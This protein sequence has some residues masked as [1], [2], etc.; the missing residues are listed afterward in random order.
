M[1]ENEETNL[2]QTT[3]NELTKEKL[4]P[5]DP[6]LRKI[7]DEAE[8]KTKDA[9]K[10]ARK[11]LR[12]SL[13]KGVGK[14]AL[15][16]LLP[17]LILIFMIIGIISFITS[18]PGIVEDMIM[19]TIMEKVDEV[20][21]ANKGPDIYLEELARDPNRTA[22]KE[23]LKYLDD[24]GLE[25][26]SLGFAA[27]YTRNEET[28]EIEYSNQ[29]DLNDIVEMETTTLWSP[30]DKALTGTG[31]LT[32]S[33]PLTEGAKA[34]AKGLL[35]FNSARNYN[36]AV[37][38]KVKSE[39]LIFK[40]IV[41]NERA[42]LVHLNDEDTKDTWDSVK[43]WFVDTFLL[44][45]DSGPA[46]TG[47]I[48]MFDKEDAVIEKVDRKDKVLTLSTV[49]SDLLNA[50]K[51]EPDDNDDNKGTYKQTAKFNL[52]G[53]SGRY[54]MSL[55][56]LLALHLATMTSDL[57]EEMITNKNLQ[58]A[59][60]LDYTTSEYRADIKV[61]YDGK[62]LPIVLGDNERALAEICPPSDYVGITSYSVYVDGEN[63]EKVKVVLKN[64]DDLKAKIKAN[65]GCVTVRSLAYWIEQV[66][67]MGKNHIHET[68]YADVKNE[69]LNGRDELILPYNERIQIENQALEAEA[70]MIEESLNP[71]I[72]NVFDNLLVAAD[73]GIEDLTL[74][75][76]K[77]IKEGLETYTNKAT[78]SI[79]YIKYVIGHWY[80]DVI[81]KTDDSENNFGNINVYDVS[82]NTIELPVTDISNEK[83]EATVVLS[84]GQSY[85]QT[86]QPY[87]IKGDLVTMD[88]EVVENVEGTDLVEKVKNQTATIENDADSD[89]TSTSDYVLGSGY[90]TTKKLFTEGKYYTYDGTQE[91]AKSIWYAK[92]IEN[93]YP[94]YEVTE[95]NSNPGSITAK[96][97][98]QEKREI[99]ERIDNHDG[100]AYVTVS[101]GRIKQAQ[102]LD[103]EQAQSLM[104]EYFNTIS[105]VQSENE[106][107]D[108]D[109]GYGGKIVT[110]GDG[111]VVMWV[112][113]ATG[114][115]EDSDNYGKTSDFY[116]VRA[117]AD[118]HYRTPAYYT[119][120][121]TQESVN[122][123]NSLLDAMGVVTQRQ[124]VSF[125][126]TTASGDVMSLTA[127]SILEGMHTLDSEYIYR[128]LKEFL[129]E[130]GYYTKS[131]FEY[132][133]TNVLTWFLPDYIPETEEEQKHWRQ[134][135]DG[136]ELYYGAILYPTETNEDGEIT[137]KGFE[138]GIDV[139]APGNCKLLSIEEKDVPSNDG[140]STEKETVIEI[141][142]DGLSQPEIGMLDGYTMIIKGIIMNTDDTIKVQNKDGDEFDVTLADIINNLNTYKKVDKDKLY[143]IKAGET[144]GY[145]GSSRIQVIMR[146][147]RG[148]LLDNV[149]DYMSPDKSTSYAQ[150]NDLGYFYFVPYEGSRPGMVSSASGDREVAVGIAQWTTVVRDSGSV[151]NIPVV[152]KKLYE[153]DPVFCSE[154][155]EFF[156]WSEQQIFDDYFN[157]GDELKNAFQAIENKDK[158][159]FMQLQMQ[160]MIEEK[161][162]LLNSRGFGWLMERNPVTVGTV[163]S[164]YNWGPNMGW[165]DHMSESMSDEQIIISMLKYACTKGSTAGD[166][167]RRWNVQAKLALDILHGDFTDIGGWIEN[168]ANYSEYSIGN[169][170]NFLS[171]K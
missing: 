41:S 135:R 166:L 115:N 50:N 132:I 76:I 66:E 103:T 171:T 4:N 27:F 136:D 138:E 29:Q 49:T 89:V 7:R 146:N 36:A 156:N 125:D 121:E 69:L 30:I 120:A 23:I 109:N 151:N 78:V 114:V 15:G 122:R 86:K 40:Y 163:W 94:Y 10:K 112:M 95:D 67:E 117:D 169:N 44:P 79:P 123:I 24:M 83:I 134:N 37:A 56:Y 14:G 1:E 88:G 80:K 61:K 3:E 42:Y 59:V 152:C 165:E 75:D 20:I 16:G 21:E 129:I 106:I 154:L 119:Y 52:E 98:A 9:T 142:F 64:V 113:R 118:L 85:A 127:F 70:K 139:V 6:V 47:M 43:E 77:E 31:Y 22:Q 131:E 159:K 144:I 148:A 68:K 71:E 35:D 164:L 87:V 65:Y 45:G 153:L 51:L 11:K 158:E 170:S 13:F 34:L 162:Q 102:I 161:T 63:K 145:T 82:N 53:Y 133:S 147:A 141:E 107:A 33:R 110:V 97:R 167:S 2:N 72:E 18:M 92:Q 81:F 157:G 155:Q 8:R 46:L 91:T 137:H 54:G 90:R 143:I 149:E 60:Y 96:I 26:S 25:P 126:N 128:D 150:V 57:T 74:T 140:K 160:V 28:G 100:Y 130:L 93:I 58:T 101:Q 73:M 32:N 84:G 19:K 105:T 17:I 38:K 168:P 12:S 39:D 62:E 116:F 111:W 104:G 5:N 124:S 48:K 108:N 55:E 99:Q